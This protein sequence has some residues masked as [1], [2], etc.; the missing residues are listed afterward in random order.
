MAVL[1]IIETRC[2]GVA[3]CRQDELYEDY[4]SNPISTS[5]LLHNAVLSVW[6][7]LTQSIK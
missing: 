6:E 3:V 4:T 5:F 7:I 2:I 1:K